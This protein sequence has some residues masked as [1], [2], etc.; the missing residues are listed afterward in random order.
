MTSIPLLRDDDIELGLSKPPPSYPAAT[1][2]SKNNRRNINGSLF[3]DGMDQFLVGSSVA[4][5]HIGIRMG[6]CN[7]KDYIKHRSC[8]IEHLYAKCL[9]FYRYNYW[10]RSYSVSYV[11]WRRVLKD[12]FS[13]CKRV[14]LFYEG[15]TTLLSAHG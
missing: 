1:D 12:L 5:A 7:E 8:C 9:A 10:Q 3:F 14:I 6:K 11:Y 4:A 15:W 13:K 2:T